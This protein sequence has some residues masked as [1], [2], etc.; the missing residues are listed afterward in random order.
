M[1]PIELELNS[2]N[3]LPVFKHAC[4]LGCS[5]RSRDWLKFKNPAAPAVRREAEKDWGKGA[6]A[7]IVPGWE[8]HAVEVARVRITEAG[9]KGA[10]EGR[11]NEAHGASRAPQTMADDAG[12]GTMTQ[13]PVCGLTL[14]KQ[15]PSSPKF[16]CERCGPFDLTGSAEQSLPSEFS[17]GLHRRALMSHKIRRMQ[18]PNQPPL[19]TTYTME[20]F[21]IEDAL[22][23]A[24]R[25]ADDLILWIGDNQVAPE[26]PQRAPL[27]FLGAWVGASL[28]NQKN[29]TAGTRWLIKY[30]EDEKL[31]GAGPKS[32]ASDVMLLQLTMPGWHRYAELKERRIETRTAFMAMQFED[33]ELN[34]VVDHCF[35]KAVAR[36]GFELRLL[37][38]GQGAGSIDNQ[39]SR[40][41]ALSE[42][43]NRRS[44]SRQSRRLLGV[45][46]CR[47]A[48]PTG[49]LH[50][51][52]SGLGCQKDSLRH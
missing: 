12:G 44:N 13:C 47:G 43:R 9:T 50:L 46:F 52:K 24:P 32:G 41:P 3:F 39:N 8:P 29:P 1:F 16:D 15:S 27:H 49:H 5:G 35:K 6:V 45:R 38:D 36:T 4:A 34:S 11:S 20:S 19:I 37:I 42:I 22:P 30:L 10:A 18:R 17:K 28:A 31:L 40:P 7:V 33:N 26:T 48:R 23:P 51:Q 2:L 25:Q 14:V 21:W